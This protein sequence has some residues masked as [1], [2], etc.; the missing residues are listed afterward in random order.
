[1]DF[2]TIFA[3][4]ARPRMVNITGTSIVYR[5]PD[6][7]AVTATAVVGEIAA[8]EQTDDEGRRREQRRSIIIGRDATAEGGGVANVREDATI[9]IGTD[10]WSIE[11]IEALTG[12]YTRVRVIRIGTVEVSRPGYRGRG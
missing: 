6:A 10:R 3:E 4:C 1:M 5:A 9:D 7:D 8:D 2:D 11:A 12:A